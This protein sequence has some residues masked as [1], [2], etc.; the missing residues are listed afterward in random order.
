MYRD[1]RQ[2]IACRSFFIGAFRRGNKQSAAFQYGKILWF[3]NQKIL[4]EK[5]FDLNTNVCYLWRLLFVVF[6]N[7]PYSRNGFQ[8]I[9]QLGYQRGKYSQLIV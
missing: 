6:S 2:V 5:W 1:E 3:V 8:C 7:R 9:A 4:Q